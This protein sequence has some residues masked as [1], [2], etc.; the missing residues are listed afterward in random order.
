MRGAATVSRTRRHSLCF[1]SCCLSL[2]GTRT[3]RERGRPCWPLTLPPIVFPL[4]PF[5]FETSKT[6]KSSSCFL[7]QQKILSDS[8]PVS[9]FSF[10]LNLQAF[11]LSFKNRSAYI[12]LLIYPFYSSREEK[13]EKRREKRETCRQN[14]RRWRPREE[15][16]E[17]E[18][19]R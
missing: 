2:K 12:R 7:A 14:W 11:S 16:E 1:C 6:F 8:Q 15:E 13:I 18:R 19:E 9:N 5:S 10:S 3:A 17:E 4:L